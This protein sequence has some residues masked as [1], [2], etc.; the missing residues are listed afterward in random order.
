MLGRV[1]LKPPELDFLQESLMEHKDIDELCRLLTY[2]RS[3]HSC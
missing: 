3:L 2:S 1:I